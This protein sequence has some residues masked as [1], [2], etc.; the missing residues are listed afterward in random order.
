MFE[1]AGTKCSP[2]LMC[3]YNYS[4]GLVS[5]DFLRICSQNLMLSLS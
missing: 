4:D 2:S 3:I 5:I 1:V